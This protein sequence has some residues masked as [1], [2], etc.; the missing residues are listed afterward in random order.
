MKDL[1][2]NTIEVGD[3]IAYP[4]RQGSSMWVTTAVVTEVT[5]RPHWLHPEDESKGTPIL[6]VTSL[7]R[8]R[9]FKGRDED[10]MPVWDV[11]YHPKKTFIERTERCVPVDPEKMP[12]DMGRYVIRI[13]EGLV[14][15]K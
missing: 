6:K 15:R 5:T 1:Y 8:R 14:T 9:T 10:Q 13:L 4:G 12:G 7:Q 11:T 3:V 2:G